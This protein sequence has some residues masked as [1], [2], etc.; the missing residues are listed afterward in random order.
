[1]DEQE[2]HAAGMIIRRAVLG[3][4]HVN[5]AQGKKTALTAGFQDLIT[6]HAWGKIWTRSGLARHTC[7]LMTICMLVALNREEELKLHLCAA[8]YNGVIRNEMK[9][10]LL[11]TAIYYGVPAANSGFSLAQEI[12][13]EIDVA[14]PLQ[15]GGC[16]HG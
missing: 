4:T 7:S 11:Q 2:R 12:F 3:D 8:S 16:S 10:A 15:Q 14:S 1:M 9:E 6:R 13:R 5:R